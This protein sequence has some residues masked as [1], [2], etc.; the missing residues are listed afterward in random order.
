[1]M[2]VFFIQRF[3]KRAGEDGRAIQELFLFLLLSAINS[4]S[5]EVVHS[6]RYIK[7]IPNVRTY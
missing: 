4:H 3:Y 2:Y 1:M 5:L 7:C 6:Y